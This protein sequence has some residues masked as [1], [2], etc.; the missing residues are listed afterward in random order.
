MPKMTHP[1]YARPLSVQDDEVDARKAAGWSLVGAPAP[2]K[3]TAAK[4]A[5]TRKSLDKKS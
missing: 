3:K 1:D 4:K 5:V 2:V